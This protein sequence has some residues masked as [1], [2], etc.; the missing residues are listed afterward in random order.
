M[1]SNDVATDPRF[2]RRADETTGFVT[3]KLICTPLIVNDECIGVLEGVN[4][5]DG[6]DGRG[7]SSRY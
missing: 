7:E 4:K 2:S 3:R 1:V 5:K 6:I